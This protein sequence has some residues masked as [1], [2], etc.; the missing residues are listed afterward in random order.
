MKKYINP[1]ISVL[2]LESSDVISLS[3][4]ANGTEVSCV[5]STP[6]RVIF[7]KPINPEEI[8][9][10]IYNGEELLK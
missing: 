5:S 8:A 9:S 4:I 1:D 10:I 2:Y 6:E 3:E 7:Q